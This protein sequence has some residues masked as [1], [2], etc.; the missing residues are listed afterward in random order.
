MLCAQGHCSAKVTSEPTRKAS[1]GS[2]VD[3]Q[4]Q[5]AL[6]RGTVCKGPED[7]CAWCV[8]SKEGETRRYT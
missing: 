8:R 7:E 5:R 6:G 2:Y 1:G 4:Q 3:L